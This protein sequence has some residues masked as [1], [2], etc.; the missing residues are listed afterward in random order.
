MRPSELRTR[1]Q[2]SCRIGLGDAPGN[3]RRNSV[4]ISSLR[5]Y[6][7]SM[8]PFK[9]REAWPADTLRIRAGAFKSKTGG[10]ASPELIP[11]WFGKP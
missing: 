10:T 2:V 4:A 5:A 8:V 6:T 1:P 11:F 9:A 7:G 3:G